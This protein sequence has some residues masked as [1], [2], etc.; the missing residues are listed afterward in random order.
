MNNFMKPQFNSK[1]LQKK[2]QFIDFNLTGVVVKENILS[3][4]KQGNMGNISSLGLLK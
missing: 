2:T 1:S 3:N 4:N